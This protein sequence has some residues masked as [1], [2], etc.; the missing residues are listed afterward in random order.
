MNAKPSTWSAEGR[1]SGAGS[2]GLVG[3]GG[4]GPL[5]RG[6]GVMAAG[7]ERGGL[8]PGLGGSWAG[9]PGGRGAG[10]QA[11]GRWGNGGFGI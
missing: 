5:G 11:D 2:V 9:E 8:G 4:R 3:G 7:W 10:Q 1:G 6:T